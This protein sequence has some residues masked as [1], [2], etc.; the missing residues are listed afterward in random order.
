MTTGKAGGV[1]PG[2][3][4]HPVVSLRCPRGT[5][6]LR[7]G[8][9]SPQLGEI[10]HPAVRRGTSA[11]FANTPRAVV[12]GADTM[13]P[14]RTEL[15]SPEADARP[16]HTGM[17]GGIPGR[18][19]TTSALDCPLGVS[20]GRASSHSS[21]GR[22]AP[23]VGRG[24]HRHP[25]S[26]EPSEL[27]PSAQQPSCCAHNLEAVHHPKC[28]GS[29]TVLDPDVAGPPEIS[30]RAGVDR[31]VRWTSR[32]DTCRPLVADRAMRAPRDGRRSA[33]SFSLDQA[34]LS[35]VTAGLAD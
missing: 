23:L 32:P 11:S 27:A 1:G 6:S 17:G 22:V 30:Q 7:C 10:P 28:R 21:P 15:P 24:G 29:K 31:F 8:D 14:P 3:P 12:L 9:E 35:P 34:W 13:S 16:W 2:A 33:G 19:G 20:A 26:L 5:D 18:R 4:T 25:A